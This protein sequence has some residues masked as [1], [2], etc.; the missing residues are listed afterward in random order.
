M[1]Q[2]SYINQV[3]IKSSNTL[4]ENTQK[5]QHNSKYEVIKQ[6]KTSTDLI[7]TTAHG[8]HMPSQLPPLL[9]RLHDQH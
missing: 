5:I 8:T 9:L 3:Y 6:A 7:T 1:Q 2:Y 4:T